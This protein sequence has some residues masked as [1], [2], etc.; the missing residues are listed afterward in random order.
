MIFLVLLHLLPS[1]LI[2]LIFYHLVYDKKRFL[3]FDN[4][5]IDIQINIKMFYNH[6]KFFYYHFKSYQLFNI[7]FLG[8]IFLIPLH[9]Y[10]LH[11]LLIFLQKNFLSHHQKFFQFSTGHFIRVHQDQ[12]IRFKL[13]YFSYSQL[14]LSCYLFDG[15]YYN[16]C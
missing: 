14:F 7:N 1:F 16:F 3:I 4:T 12:I 2:F 11:T 15:V 10:D 13:D 6:I 9:L 5:C 8:Q